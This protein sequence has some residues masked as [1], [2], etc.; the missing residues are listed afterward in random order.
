MKCEL[1]FRPVLNSVMEFDLFTLHPGLLKLINFYMATLNRVVLTSNLH[2]SK[3]QAMAEL[4]PHLPQR[5]GIQNGD[6]L[7][8][9]K[10][11]QGV[12]P[13]CCQNI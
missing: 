11:L 3:H 6:R 9:A 2:S 5:P 1:P 13:V 7:P 10:R 4:I 12:R 8:K